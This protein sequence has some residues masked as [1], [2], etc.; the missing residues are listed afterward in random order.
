MLASANT[1]ITTEINGTEHLLL[2]EKLYGADMGRLVLP[3]GKS[4]YEVMPAQASD[5]TM[6]A[7]FVMLE[8]PFDTALRETYEETG[9][10]LRSEQKTYP[11][12][13]FTV[14]RFSAYR[15]NWLVD[16]A[17][18]ITL[19]RSHISAE[20]ARTAVDS[21]ELR[22][23]WLPTATLP[24]ERMQADIPYWLKTGLA[25]RPDDCIMGHISYLPDGTVERGLYFR[26]SGELSTELSVTAQYAVNVPVERFPYIPCKWSGPK[27]V[28][29]L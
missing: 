2:G 3:G 27:T 15:N 18:H 11:I 26:K 8:H 10:D 19:V 9:I 7:A 22:L 14:R 17:F 6:P 4:D 13:W 29:Q 21:N 16:H 28:T 23:N 12:G 20:L 24:Y 25:A 1:L 5:D